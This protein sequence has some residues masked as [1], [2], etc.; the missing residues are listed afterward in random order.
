MRTPAFHDD[1]RIGELWIERAAE[2]A[3][4]ARTADLAPASADKE[5]IAAFGIDCQVGFC[6]PGASLFVPGAVDD[7]RRTLDWLYRNME[8]IT[9]LHFSLDTHRVFQIFHPAWWTDDKGNHPAPFTPIFHEDVRAGRWT[10]LAHPREC[11]EYTKRLEETG[12]YVLT[13]WPFHTLLGGLSHALV[14]SLMEAAIFHAVARKAQTHFETKGTHAMTENYSV[15]SPE[16]KELGHKSVGAFNAPFFKLLMDYDKVYVFGQAKS[17]CVLATLKDMEAQCDPALLDK[18]L[19]PRGLHEPGAAAA[20]RPAA[21]LAR[22]PA[23]RRRGHGGLQAR[24][25][26][27][28]SLHGGAP[29]THGNNN[30]NNKN[31]NALDVAALFSRAQQTGTLSAQSATLLSGDLGALVIAGAAGMAADDIQASD[32]TLITLVLDASSSIGGRGLEQAVC[33]GER[34]LLDAFA[35]SKEKDAVLVALWT[36]QSHA[37]VVHGYVPVDDAVR[38]Q[39]G[40]TYRSGGTT[41]LYDTFIDACAANVAYAQRLRDAGTPTRSI[42]VVVTDGQDVGSRRSARACRKLAADLLKSEQFILAFVGVGDDDFK[43][44]AANMG[45]PDGCV[46]VQKDATPAGLRGAFQMVSQSAVRASQG[47]VAPGAG[48]GFFAP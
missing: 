42:V 48:A 30:G 22:L 44:V 6:T 36:F 35:G 33:D 5:R 43:T 1:K 3:D 38:L 29:V 47:R 31:R 39:P 45:F 18:I 24:R 34:A 17:H 41:H 46:L 15:L 25:H 27:H 2:V 37:D 4:A 40:A 21:A 14:P 8:R 28:R 10:P 23:H 7:M 16:V 26:A 20:A 13:V 12:K 19:D 32:V 11:L 9:A